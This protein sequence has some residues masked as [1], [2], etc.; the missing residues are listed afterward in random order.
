MILVVM[1][2]DEVIN[3]RNSGPAHRS[4]EPAAVSVLASVHQERCTRGRNKERRGA[5]LNVDMRNAQ[6]L[7]N[8]RAADLV[9]HPTESV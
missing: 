3:P 9:R 2:N 8:G 5:L 7:G 4:L 1:R 6:G